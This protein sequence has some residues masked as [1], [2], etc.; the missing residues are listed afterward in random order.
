MEL[1]KTLPGG[2]TIEKL[3]HSTSGLYYRTCTGSGSICK[4]T[5]NMDSAMSIATVFENYY[6]VSR[7]KPPKE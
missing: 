3:R 5:P 2:T 4:F 1:I 7:K 6:K